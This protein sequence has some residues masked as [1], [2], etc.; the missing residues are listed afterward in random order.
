MRH[1]NQADFLYRSAP[2]HHL[3]TFDLL[4]DPRKR[5][6]L[7]IVQHYH[8]KY[9]SSLIREYLHCFG[10]LATRLRSYF[11]PSNSCYLVI[12]SDRA[13]PLLSPIC[14]DSSSFPKSVFVSAGT[15]DTLHSD[16][17]RIVEKLK[18]DGHPNAIFLEC[19]GVG[20]GY[21]KFQFKSDGPDNWAMITLEKIV[22]VIRGSWSQNDAPRNGSANASVNQDPFKGS[23]KSSALDS[24]KASP[25]PSPNGSIKGSSRD[26][27]M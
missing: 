16:G 19:K 17:L 25:K 23:P 13:D 2:S 3:L 21:E 26:A 12:N 15:G 8:R 14:A 10:I 24:V 6:L 27:K 20:H 7:D 18:A 9:L 1:S 22:E 5:L 4:R 11:V